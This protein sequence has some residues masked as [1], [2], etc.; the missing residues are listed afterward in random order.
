MHVIL[1]FYVLQQNWQMT[2]NLIFFSSFYCPFVCDLMT[3]HIFHSSLSSSQISIAVFGFN[4]CTNCSTYFF[5]TL[6][7]LV[8]D[9][10]FESFDF[11]LLFASNSFNNLIARFLISVSVFARIFH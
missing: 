6:L 3:R 10:A 8:F 9:S 2:L 1:I 5:V 11:S 4:V 7:R